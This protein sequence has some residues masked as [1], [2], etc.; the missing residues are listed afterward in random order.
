M[1]TFLYEDADNLIL[2]ETLY[3]RYYRELLRVA[4]CILKNTAKVEDAV[5]DTFVNIAS[6]VETIRD[7]DDETQ[8]NYIVTMVR[9]KSI[10]FLRADRREIV[11]DFTDEKY[12]EI[13]ADSDI[14]NEL[15]DR[16]QE[17]LLLREM[18]R[19]KE[20][21]RMVL[22]YY[23][24]RELTR[25]EIADLMDADVKMVDVWLHRARMK[26]AKVLGLKQDG[27]KK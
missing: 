3:K 6:H 21:Y 4:Y 2:F 12:S 17:V 13:S 8:R 26:F 15:C 25:E 11:R 5:H 22:E 7:L 24:F 14:L 27:K 9:N 1:Y 20:K 19:L 10:D 23:Y 18:D 16:E